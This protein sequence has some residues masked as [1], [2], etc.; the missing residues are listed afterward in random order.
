MD[1][2]ADDRHEMR[3]GYGQDDGESGRPKKCGDHFL[4]EQICGQKTHFVLTSLV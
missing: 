1:E 2:A 3:C 4:Q